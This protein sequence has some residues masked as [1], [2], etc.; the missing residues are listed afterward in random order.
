M[1]LAFPSQA[2]IIN[3][4]VFVQIEFLR[5]YPYLPFG[6]RKRSSY[7]NLILKFLFQLETTGI[8]VFKFRVETKYF[9]IG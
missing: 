7:S 4:Y 5:I 3:M 6:R 9:I 2:Q 8:N 1:Y